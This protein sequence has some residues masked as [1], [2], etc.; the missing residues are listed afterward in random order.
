MLGSGCGIQYTVSRWL[1]YQILWYFIVMTEFGSDWIGWNL[2]V[3]QS[4][5][6]DVM[7]DPN[8]GLALVEV[9]ARPRELVTNLG[10]AAASLSTLTDNNRVLYA[11]ESPD[12]GRWISDNMPE[13]KNDIQELMQALPEVM[14]PA[15]VA[16]G[17]IGA[18]MARLQFIFGLRHRHK[19]HIDEGVVVAWC[20][21]DKPGFF[22]VKDDE[23]V[24]IPSMPE[25]HVLL[26]RGEN[27]SGPDLPGVRHGVVYRSSK[28]RR[29]VLIGY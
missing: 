17:G 24:S 11:N 2:K 20:G 14:T 4:D 10:N 23:R 29:A 13:L 25:E 7:S 15:A 8:G 6:A 18:K 28:V 27:F 22:V 12:S 16:L 21:A 5:I 26:M 19:G 1:F 9:A 3:D